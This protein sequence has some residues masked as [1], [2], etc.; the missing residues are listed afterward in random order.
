MRKTLRTAAALAGIAA[1]LASVGGPAAVAS[2][3][4]ARE[5]A[6]KY[7]ETPG[8]A[9][10]LPLTTDGMLLAALVVMY[11]RRWQDKPTG[12]VPWLAFI[13]GGVATL[14]ANLA[15]ADLASTT[16]VGDVVGRLATAVWPPIAF[17]VTLELVAVMLGFLRRTVDTPAWPATWQIGIPAYPYQPPAPPA[18]PAQTITPEQVRVPGPLDVPMTRLSVPAGPVRLDP[19]PAGP[20]T[21]LHRREALR[22]TGTPGTGTPRNGK[23][24]RWTDQDEAYRMELQG[25]I[26]EAGTFPTV[27]S[28]RDRYGMG[29]D[30]AGRI[31]GRLV[32]PEARP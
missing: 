10:W 11:A 23:A 21:G 14:A 20:G 28:V 6:V 22:R 12:F 2:Y 27:R 13:A 9:D 24:V 31:V 4:H 16:S 3:R 32:K 18:V 25:E 30:R 29:A 15:A 26:D 5:V 17:A 19:V 8:M 7:G 1:I